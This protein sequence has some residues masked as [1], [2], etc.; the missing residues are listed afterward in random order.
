MKKTNEMH[1][2]H[3]EAILDGHVTNESYRLFRKKGI[4]T[5]CWV[6]KDRT[7]HVFIDEEPDE[8]IKSLHYHELAHSRW[9]ERDLGT[10]KEKLDQHKIPFRLYNLFEDARIEHLTREDLIYQFNWKIPSEDE[11]DNT[12]FGMFYNMVQNNGDDSVCADQKVVDYFNR[13]INAKDSWEVIPIIVDWLNDFPEENKEENQGEDKTPKNGFDLERSLE[14]FLDNEKLLE[15]ISLSVEVN[16]GENQDAPQ[17]Q[18]NANEA[19]KDLPDF[20]DTD[21]IKS[22]K[23]L[24]IDKNVVNKNTQ[25]LQKIFRSK[26]G[27]INTKRPSK[28]L[29]IKGI[30]QD[31]ENI[32]KQKVELRRDTRKFNFIVDLSGSMGGVPI[33]AAANIVASFNELAK[34]GLLKGNL[35]LTSTYGYQTFSFPLKEYTIEHSFHTS[36]G[37]GLKDTMEKTLNILKQGELNFCL[38]DGKL[39][40]GKIDRKL[41]NSKGVKTYGLYIGTPD[42]ATLSNWFDYS[43]AKET[44]DELIEEITRQLIK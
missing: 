27:Y 38:T 22:Y 2:C 23:A 26:I 35:I 12:P 16:F 14:L 36:G 21:Y 37:E 19:D 18:D 34:Q 15:L 28:R 20:S 11:Q 7:H 17:G 33:K 24:E 3:R 13:T 1:S 32:Y 44:I 41:F 4:K 30:I 39:T 25:K 40:D 42:Y 9:T 8:E 10:L 31:S 5:A 6:F 29:N 43:C